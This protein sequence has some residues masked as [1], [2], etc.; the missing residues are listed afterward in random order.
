MKKLSIILSLLFATLFHT[1][2][3]N[4]QNVGETTALKTAQA[5]VQTQ[6]T[7]KSQTLSLVSSEGNYIYNIGNQGFVIISS[8]TALPPVLAWSDQG[9]FPDLT[10]A[11]ENFRSWIE[12]YSEMI[13][14][15][16]ANGIAPEAVVQG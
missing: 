5:F 13:D 3:Q 8:N 11:P 14:F 4:A 15:A 2:A 7:L 9:N 16:I 12:H 1:F 6:S 10:E